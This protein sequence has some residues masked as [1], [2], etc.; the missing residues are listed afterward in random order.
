LGSWHFGYSC[1]FGIGAVVAGQCLHWLR[2]RRYDVVDPLLGVVKEEIVRFQ[3]P[4]IRAGDELYYTPPDP[5]GASLAQALSDPHP[6]LRH[7]AA[8]ALSQI[9]PAAAPALPEV[10]AALRSNNLDQEKS[11]LIITLGNIGPP[12]APAVPLLVE[13]MSLEKTDLTRADAAEAL[14]KIGD[15]EGLSS[16]VRALKTDESDHVRHA[17]AYAIAKFGERAR[18]AVPTL[19]ESLND[20]DISVRGAS[21]YAIAQITGEPF[22]DAD[23]HDGTFKIADNGEPYIVIAA[24]EWW[25]R[26]GRFQD[27]NSP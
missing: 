24:R 8:R 18:L 7:F 25:E 21:A 22:P 16:L 13:M 26:E 1:G 6:D 20:E 5:S 4:A 17:A 2:R 9:G 3:Q 27:W 23:R 10:M 14:G 19:V 12:A 15:E 11:F